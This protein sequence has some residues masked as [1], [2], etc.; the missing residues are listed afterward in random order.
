MSSERNLSDDAATSAVTEQPAAVFIASVVAVI[1]TIFVLC[2]GLFRAFI[3]RVFA[4]S[5]SQF[6]VG[7]N[8]RTE[9]RKEQLFA[10]LQRQVA[11]VVTAAATSA[12]TN[13]DATFAY[14]RD[15]CW[16]GSQLQVLSKR[17]R[18]ARRPA[19]V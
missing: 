3:K 2:F 14:R 11:D 6:A 10:G 12:A 17:V 18:I 7:Y 15:R 1:V 4:G 19:G 9:R 16:V 13:Y 8:D 5:I